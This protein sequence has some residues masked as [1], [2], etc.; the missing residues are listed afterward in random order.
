MEFL[1]TETLTGLGKPG[2]M[3]LLP[4][5]V[6]CGQRSSNQGEPEWLLLRLL[7]KLKQFDSRKSSAEGPG[8][9]VRE[10]G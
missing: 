7:E 1:S 3:Q 2:G 10:A 5:V 8:L 6:H 9:E 4:G